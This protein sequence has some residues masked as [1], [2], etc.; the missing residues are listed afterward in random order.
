MAFLCGLVYRVVGARVVFW[1]TD[2]SISADRRVGAVVTAL[3]LG[4]GAVPGVPGEGRSGNDTKF[5]CAFRVCQAVGRLRVSSALLIVFT[6]VT[7]DEGDDTISI[8]GR[9]GGFPLDSPQHDQGDTAPTPALI[10]QVT[11]KK[12]LRVVT[13]SY[14]QHFL[15]A[16]C[17]HQLLC[18]IAL[19]KRYNI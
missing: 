17:Y 11:G 3:E 19:I 5:A 1:R 10:R 6:E 13:Q 16:H 4:V 14:S 9:E 2:S 15:F 12:H 18:C 8:T 7:A